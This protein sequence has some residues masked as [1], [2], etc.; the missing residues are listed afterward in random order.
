[1]AEDKH[2]YGYRDTS[3]A[4]SSA[5]PRSVVNQIESKTYTISVKNNK[6]NPEN[7]KI[8]KGSIVV[9]QICEDSLDT[10][11]TSLYS[12]NSRSHVIAFQVPQTE[13]PLLKLND[14]FKVKFLECGHFS[15]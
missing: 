5:I 6:F 8:E 1:V 4:V 10:V 11:E 14:T 9:W 7:L 15:Y 12:G 2:L 3:K 13:S